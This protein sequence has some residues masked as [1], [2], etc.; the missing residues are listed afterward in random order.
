[1]KTSSPLAGISRRHSAIQVAGALAVM[2]ASLGCGSSD[3]A[4]DLPHDV[5]DADDAS[6]DGRLEATTEVDAA[7]ADETAD[8][9]AD[10]TE[11]RGSSLCPIQQTTSAR[12]RMA[13]SGFSGSEA[14]YFALYSL[15]CQSALDC[16][17]PCVAAGATRASCMDASECVAGQDG[18]M[19]CR[20][21]TYWLNTAGALAESGR[22]ASAATLILV[23][24]DYNDTLVLTNFGV[25]IPDDATI[26]GIQFRVRHNADAGLA[27]DHAVRILRNGVPVG[28]DHSQTSAWPAALT[29][30]AYGD[31]YDV[32]GTSW[33][34]EDVRATGFG[35]SVAARY[36][37]VVGN[38]RAHVDSV[39]VTVFYRTPCD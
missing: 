15:T 28:A 34:V 12:A 7:Y 35:A 18:G 1:M 38:D 32:W 10:A 25:S 2:G 4:H 31:A 5:T 29:Y 33:T 14:Q 21:P 13:A 8:G 39:R 36:T 16:I 20:P 37:D 19:M 3:D 17:E 24:S 23:K 6:D 30:A 11:D 26:S 9:S 22:M 27:V